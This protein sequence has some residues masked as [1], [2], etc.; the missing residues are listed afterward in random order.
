[1]RRTLFNVVAKLLL[2]ASVL[3]CLLW[4]RS[5]SSAS[6]VQRTSYS[7]DTPTSARRVILEAASMSGHLVVERSE[8]SING[9][10]ET[11]AAARDEE[12]MGR[13]S[14]HGQYD[15]L[16]R[17]PDAA[18]S[19]ANRL[20]FYHMTD[21]GGPGT[22]NRYVIPTWL[23]AVV[24]FPVTAWMVLR[25]RRSRVRENRARAGLCP[26]CGYDL[27]ASAGRCPE[28]GTP[29]TAAPTPSATAL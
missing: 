28:C 17:Y 25:E 6:T 20:G 12:A 27:R 26:Q 5:Y 14:V 29:G 4:I 7:F 22:L 19:P 9:F 24:L 13:W 18:K 15:F 23:V 3:L 2:T 11:R 10:E 16:R 21:P 8:T 1:L